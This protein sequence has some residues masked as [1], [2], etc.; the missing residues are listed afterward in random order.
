VGPENTRPGYLGRT[1][2]QMTRYYQPLHEGLR[3]RD[4]L[5]VLWKRGTVDEY[6]KAYN[7]LAIKVPQ[8]TLEEKLYTFIKGLKQN[9]QVGVFL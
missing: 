6:S 9:V 2:A 7:E 1:Q 8:M 5:Y 4:A 3:A